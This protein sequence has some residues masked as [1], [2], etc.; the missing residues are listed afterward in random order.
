MSSLQY[1]YKIY[2]DEYFDNLRVGN[3]TAQTANIGSISASGLSLSSLTLG[4]S[5]ITD[6]SQITGGGVGATGATGPTGPAGTATIGA[7][8]AQGPTGPSGNGLPGPTGATGVAGPT[9]VQGPAGD[10]A[11][12]TTT[13]WKYTTGVSLDYFGNTTPNF[14]TPGIE[15]TTANGITSVLAIADGGS[16]ALPTGINGSAI[17]PVIPNDTP[18]LQFSPTTNRAVTLSNLTVSIEYDYGALFTVAQPATVIIRV[19]IYTGTV[20]PN[21]GSVIG[22]GSDYQPTLLSIDFTFTIPPNDSGSG[23][24]LGNSPVAIVVPANTKVLLAAYIVDA[25]ANIQS[26]KFRT[27]INATV[28]VL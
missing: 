7:T 17:N 1:N 18:Y 23:A 21:S 24:L 26:I 14:G 27:G 15:F 20:T 9:G 11:L 22:F 6:F 10:P 13:L 16:A 25:S 8:G 4:A 3:L 2:N 12:T 28:S 19:G 5:T